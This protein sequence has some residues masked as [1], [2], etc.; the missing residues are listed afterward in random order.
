ML[1][2]LYDQSFLKARNLQPSKNPNLDVLRKF[3]W[4]DWYLVT[5][6]MEW[7]FFYQVKLNTILTKW[8]LC[9]NFNLLASN[10]LLHHDKY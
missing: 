1:D 7:R 8:G 10:S 6:R 2:L 4:I 3:S 9:M 5:S